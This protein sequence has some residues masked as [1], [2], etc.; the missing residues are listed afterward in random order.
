[1]PGQLVR[2]ERL[3]PE[4]RDSRTPTGQIEIGEMAGWVC[5]GASVQEKDL[6]VYLSV[7]A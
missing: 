7:K 1:M 2:A 4:R 3:L 6:D 5:H